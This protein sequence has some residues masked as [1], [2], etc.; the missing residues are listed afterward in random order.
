MQA[1]P[2]GYFWPA[3]GVSIKPL[4]D[5]FLR[6]IK[7]IIAPLL[8]ST[9]VVGIAGTGGGSGK[10]FGVELTR[11]ARQPVG[12]RPAAVVRAVV[13]AMDE[14]EVGQPAPQLDMIGVEHASGGR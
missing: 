1:I 4:A 3:F 9:L 11:R 14:A 13:A 8:F 5:A 7:M 2:G 6:M 10:L 12:H